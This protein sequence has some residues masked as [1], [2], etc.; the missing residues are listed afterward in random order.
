MKKDYKNGQK[1]ISS[2]E[3]ELGMGRVTEVE[4]RLV[5]LHFDLVEETRTYARDQ[6]PLTRVRFNAGDWIRALDDIELLVSHVTEK[7]GIL[8]YQGDYRGT[9][10]AVIETDLDPNITFSKP[11]ERLFTQVFLFGR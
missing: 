6:A 5:T 10:T 4:H 8:V 7:D 2:A 11:E 9:A 1:W 3:P